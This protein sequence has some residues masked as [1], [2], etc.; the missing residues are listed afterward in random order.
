MR[1]QS[2]TTFSLPTF[3]R[4]RPSPPFYSVKSPA[5]GGP[6]PTTFTTEV[7]PVSRENPVT[8]HSPNVPLRHWITTSP[9]FPVRDRR[10]PRTLNHTRTQL[11]TAWEWWLVGCRRPKVGRL[12][13]GQILHVSYL[14]PWVSTHQPTSKDYGEGF[15]LDRPMV[16]PGQRTRLRK[17]VVTVVAGLVLPTS[18]PKGTPGGV[19]GTSV[20]SRRQG[21]GPEERRV[22][23]SGPVTTIEGRGPPYIP[24][25]VESL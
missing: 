18:T 19:F 4:P 12:G 11:T 20:P 8:D 15:A 25:R 1:V 5:L 10:F 23:V 14:L 13:L 22:G 16:R 3:A 17:G 9:L 6:S 7:D 24:Y 21:R 2:T